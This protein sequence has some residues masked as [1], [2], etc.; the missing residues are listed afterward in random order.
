[1]LSWKDH[2]RFLLAG[3]IVVGLVELSTPN[4]ALAA[5]S[6]RTDFCTNTRC[7]LTYMNMDLGNYI[8]NYGY[9]VEGEQSG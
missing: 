1:M 3:V 6:C 8:C 7:T 4:T 9:W 5:G 2:L